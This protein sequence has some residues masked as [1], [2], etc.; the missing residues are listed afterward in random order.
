MSYV[1]GNCTETRGLNR[2]GASSRALR[3]YGHAV[4]NH[5]KKY[6]STQKSDKTA[7]FVSEIAWIRQ[8]RNFRVPIPNPST[9]KTLLAKSDE[10]SRA[11]RQLFKARDYLTNHCQLGNEIHARKPA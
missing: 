1:S 2:Y 10:A 4:T 3:M 7:R 9:S 8:I 5:R 6:F 11:K